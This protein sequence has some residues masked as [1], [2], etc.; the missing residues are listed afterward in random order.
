MVILKSTGAVTIRPD[1][2]KKKKNQ[3]AQS[4]LIALVRIREDSYVV[5][6]LVASILLVIIRRIG[7]L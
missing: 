1:K 2:K 4:V 5:D 6:I 3:F 7:L